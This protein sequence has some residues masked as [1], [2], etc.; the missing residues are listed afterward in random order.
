MA[1]TL[2]R[3]MHAKHGAYYLVRSNK[4]TFLSRN[5]HDALVEYA[6]LTAGPDKGALG[7]LVSRALSDMKL[8]VAPST[9]KNYSTCSRRVLEAFAEFTPQQIKP[10]HVAAFLD[11]NKATPSMANLLRSFLKGMFT[12]AVRW[13]IVEANPVRDIEQF[14]TGKRDRYITAEEFK[15]IREHATPTLQCLM[16]LAYITG[17]RMGDVIKIRYSDISDQGV[18]VRQQK[19]GN[20]VLITMTPDL[21]AAIKQARTI[22][23]SVKGMTLLH[24]RD[25]TA[26]A[27]GTIHH[28][29][30]KACTDAKVA[31]AHFHDIRA[32]SATDARKQG[33]DSKTLLGHTTDSSH[34]RYLRDKETPVAMPVTAR[35]S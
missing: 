12:R 3:W 19:T 23:Q 11:D 26:L 4:W 18:F 9:F 20:R 32:A 2:P 29:W 34:N 15:A 33:L 13:G 28:Q 22:H 30:V 16:D 5:L 25:G 31:D 21:D 10:Q 17:Q 8:T 6:R 7:E 27:Y 24:K 35:K 1:R 14:K